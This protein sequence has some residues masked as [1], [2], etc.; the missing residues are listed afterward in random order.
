[1]NSRVADYLKNKFSMSKLVYVRTYEAFEHI[2]MHD[3]L[4]VF[5]VG[6]LSFI[7]ADYFREPLQENDTLNSLVKKG[8]ECFFVFLN[9]STFK[10]RTEFMYFSLHHEEHQERQENQQLILSN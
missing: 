7:F 8:S 1:M 5:I 2:F 9:T 10:M 6:R 3:T 4:I